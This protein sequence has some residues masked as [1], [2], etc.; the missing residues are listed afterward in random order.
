M[1]A[2]SPG[3][4]NLSLLSEFDP[5]AEPGSGVPDPWYGT[6]AGFYG[7]LAAV[8]SA[9]P[10]VIDRVRALVASELPPPVSQIAPPEPAVEIADPIE[11]EDDDIEASELDDETEAEARMIVDALNARGQACFWFRAL[12]NAEFYLRPRARRP[13]ASRRLKALHRRL[14]NAIGS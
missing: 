13:W 8:E 1:T 2:I 11:E 6:P 5:D 12:N 7:T 9:M 14:L 4:T 10:G 3:A